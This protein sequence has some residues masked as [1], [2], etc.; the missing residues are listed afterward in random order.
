MNT[1]QTKPIETKTDPKQL[2]SL[3]ESITEGQRRGISLMRKADGQHFWGDRLRRMIHTE[4]DHQLQPGTDTYLA[5]TQPAYRPTLLSIFS[6]EN[7]EAHPAVSIVLKNGKQIQ[8]SR[9]SY[10]SEEAV[11]W[12]YAWQQLGS[13]SRVGRG[14]EDGRPLRAIGTH[15]DITEQVAIRHELEKKEE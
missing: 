15:V 10:G 9:Y 5:C 6:P 7:T 4:P 8:L 1:M 13:S 2:L 12:V 3:L 14:P 11:F